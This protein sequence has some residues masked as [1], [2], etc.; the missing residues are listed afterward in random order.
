M[1]IT[2]GRKLWFGFTSILVILIVVGASGLWSLTKLNEEY[3]YFLDNNVKSVLLFEQLLS[4]QHEDAKNM[5]GY[6][7]YKEESY[8]TQR[9]EVLSSFKNKLQEVDKLIRTADQR[10]LLKAVK[11]ASLSYRDISD[12]AI[13]DVQ[14]GSLETAAKIAAE[15]E[16]YEEAVN[17]TIKNLIEHQENQQAQM[18]KELQ[19]VL[20]WIQ[21]LIAGLVG[22]AVIVTVII[23]RLISRHCTAG[24]N[25]DN[26]V[27]T[28]CYREFFCGARPNPQQR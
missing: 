6:L 5:H 10:E 16:I 21:Q 14:E 8:L 19:Q 26:G 9:D 7:I 17:E 18:E 24:W 22:V 3:R 4:N 2:V 23:A 12:I 13:R 11:D 25:D 27:E 15:G 28:T 1:R 20:T